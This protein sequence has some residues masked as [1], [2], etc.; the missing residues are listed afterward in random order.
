MNDD[1]NGPPADHSGL[2]PPHRPEWTPEATA[3]FWDYWH[4]RTDRD[5]WYFS[6]HYAAA[7][8]GCARAFGILRGEVLDYGFGPGFL[9]GRLLEEDVSVHGIEFSEPTVARSAAVWGGHP[10]WRG[11]ISV[12]ELPSSVPAGSFDLI[13]CIEVVEHLADQWLAATVGELYRLAKP[14]GHVFLTTPCEERLESEF[15]YCPFCDSEFH[16]VQHLRSFR[17]NDLQA[18]LEASGFEVRFCRGIDLYNFG[19]APSPP[20]FSLLHAAFR[21]RRLF[22]FGLPHLVDRLFK[23]TGRPG[24]E[25]R[26]AARRP[27]RHLC[28]IARKP[29][30]G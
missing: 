22:R 6:Y 25:F 8:I 3:R 19:D 7:I 29:L 12:A 15:V 17:P 21:A 20:S 4:R 27:G 26:R 2:P 10:R 14:G 23:P 11:A 30:A 16:S 5:S 1:W 18:M 28:A 24:W 13:F 9:V